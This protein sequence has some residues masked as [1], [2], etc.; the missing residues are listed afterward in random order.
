MSFDLYYNGEDVEN[1]RST[2]HMIYVIKG[3]R[4]CL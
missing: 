3:D 1:L 4:V 2:P